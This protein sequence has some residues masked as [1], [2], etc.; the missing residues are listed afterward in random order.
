MLHK[1][2]ITIVNDPLGINEIKRCEIEHERLFD[3]LIEEYGSDGF[4]VP[5]NVYLDDFRDGKQ[6]DLHEHSEDGLPLENI[7]HVVILHMP[8][9]L[10]LAT[11]GAIASILSFVITVVS[12]FMQ[13]A[14][15]QP[16]IPE[17]EK[18]E[19]SPN[20]GL[21]AQTNIARP[22]QRIPD[23]YGTNRVYP[24]LIAKSYFE[25]INNVKFQTEF[26]CIGRGEFQVDDLKSGDTLISDI[27]GASATVFG[28]ST[29]PAELLDVT[30]SNEVN[31]QDVL[32][33]N[34]TKFD[35]FTITDHTITGVS[36]ITSGEAQFLALQDLL[37]GETFAF[38][39]TGGVNDGTYTLSTFVTTGTPL[40]P[41]YTVTIVEATLTN[42]GPI[43]G[44]YSTTVLN[45]G[46]GPFAVPG[47]TPEEVWIDFQWQQGIRTNNNTTIRLDYDLLLQPI[48]SNGDPVGPLETNSF[49]VNANEKTLQ[50]KT[51]KFTVDSPG[52]LYEATVS[53]TG[54]SVSSNY[55]Q[56]KWTRLAGVE[57]V[58]G[59]DFGNVTTV[60][61]ETEATEQATKIQRREFNAVATRKLV[62]YDTG[63][64]T[65]TTV[66]NS[67]ARFADAALDILTDPKMGN[68][69]VA[70]I[71]LDE[72][73]DIQESL[74]NDV[75]YG[76]KL[77]RFCYSYSNAL[78]SVSD[79]LEACLNAAR[80]TKYKRGPIFHFVRDQVQPNRLGLFNRRNKSPDGEVKQVRFQLPSDVDGVELEWTDENTGEGNTVIL[81]IG[82]SVNP[83]RIQA[84]GIKNYEQAWNRA[85]YEFARITLQRKS[86]DTK[87]TAEGVLLPI[88]GRVGNVDGT[89]IKTQDGGVTGVNVLEITT[90]E[91][92][93]FEGNPT[94]TVFLRKDDGTPDGPFVVSPL[95]GNTKGFILDSIPSFTPHV[96]GDNDYQVE[97]LY[98]FA[99]DSNHDAEDYLV[100]E[101]APQGDGYVKMSLLNYDPAI[102][103]ADTTTPTP[104]VL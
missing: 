45:P 99:P 51:F 54:S 57:D 95:P 29:G 64:Q 61:V 87:V 28:P 67:T 93:D 10:E 1:T 34:G 7:N 33:P 20:N 47:S 14:I 58:S 65:I 26:L 79:E 73:Y 12:F 30:E 5:T 70:N 103:N 81:P 86:V 90:T 2:R 19:E 104:Q 15:P 63:T 60:L 35:P 37:P 55:D 43:T 11:I 8:A 53:W 82:G 32:G 17:V 22:L 18:P 9:G 49:V 80:C 25:F 85:T 89:S 84:A 96:R 56:A 69:P 78:T 48:D 83:T 38:T 94:G 4:E 68:T 100:V 36:T 91:E 59:I 21:T 23:I 24:D 42:V 74:E 101:T 88:N 6:V 41:I 39:E 72:L 76:D 27:V 77:V 46:V 52:D 97:T 31:G 16:E 50:N 40:V 92:I 75:I 71:D 98:S 102:Y 62:T 3:F 13:P 66:P 44:N